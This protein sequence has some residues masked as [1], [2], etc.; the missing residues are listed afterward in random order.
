MLEQLELRHEHI[1]HELLPLE[2]GSRGLHKLG[3]GVVF[4][5]RRPNSLASGLERPPYGLPE[6]IACVECVSK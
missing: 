1:V 6:L 5:Q 3:D 4:L 2:Y